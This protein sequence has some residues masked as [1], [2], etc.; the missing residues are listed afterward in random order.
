MSI[1]C[2]EIGNMIPIKGLVLQYIIATRN[3]TYEIF[4][5]YGFD[6][7]TRLLIQYDYTKN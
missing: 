1:A 7:S 6:Y 3:K 5:F 2:K 4:H